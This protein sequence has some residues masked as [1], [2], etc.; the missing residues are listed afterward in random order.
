MAD[1]PAGGGGRTAT[2]GA[3]SSGATS[4]TSV[5][6]GGAN[7]KGSWVEFFAAT[8]F[9]ATGIMLVCNFGLASFLMD[10]GVGAAGSEQVLVPNIHHASNDFNPP[11][12]LFPVRVPAGSRVAA[13]LQST[14]GTANPSTVI[15]LVGEGFAGGPGRNRI[16]AY[17]ADT[18]DSGGTV[19]DPG[20]TAHTKG[21][22]VQLTAATECAHKQLALA[23]GNRANTAASSSSFL[24]DIGVGPAGSEQLVL[25][26]YRVCTWVNETVSP[27]WSPFLPVD[28]PAGSRLAVRCQSTSTDA[29]DRLLDAVL[30]G[31]T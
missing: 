2:A 23:L 30:Y 8:E 1:W 16:V 29:T 20:G 9:P 11:A 31:V 22:W 24:F 28:I 12:I 21:S 27:P 3:S 17:G 10:I 19:V 18:T 25:A 26:D 5:T 7:T 4:G 13:R 15:Y 6:S 14:N